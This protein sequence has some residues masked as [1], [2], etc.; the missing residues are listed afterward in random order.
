MKSKQSI[1][2]PKFLKIFGI[3][4]LV[5]L[6][7]FS[8]LALISLKLLDSYTQNKRWDILNEQRNHIE[9]TVVKYCAAD[10]GRMEY[11]WYMYAVLL[12]FHAY[13]ACDD[14]YAELC[15]GDM[16]IATDRDTAIVIIPD[17]GTNRSFVLSIEDISYLDPLDEYMDGKISYKK[18]SDRMI[19]N[20]YDPLFAA[21][22]GMAEYVGD[23]YSYEVQTIYI[24]YEENTFIPGIVRVRNDEGESY[25]VDCTPMDTKG[26]EFFELDGIYEDYRTL[27]IFYRADP[28]LTLDNSDLLIFSFPDMTY[29][30][31]TQEEYELMVKPEIADQK[32]PWMITYT[33]PVEKSVFEL[34]PIS[35]ALIIYISLFLALA[36]SLLLAFVKYQR[37]KTI[38]NIFLYRTKTTEAMAHDLKT[39]LAAIRAYAENIE[40]SADDPAKIREYSKNITDK[41]ESMDQMITDILSLS[42]SESR[43]TVVTAEPVSVQALIKESLTAFPDMKTEITGDDVTLKTDRKLFKQAI[44]NLFSNCDRYGDKNVTVIIGIS[45]EALTIT[46]ST[47]MNYA[48][49]ESL[50]QP[51]VKGDNTRGSK[52]TG[53]GLSIADNNLNILGYRL[54]LT[55]EKRTFT[56]T[57][58]FKA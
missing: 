54:G 4:L 5:C 45:P 39:P 24:N 47:N 18:L 22:P 53:L 36:I 19:K 28:D 23:E 21:T 35:S 51:F 1:T 48:D 52:G 16:K 26:Y 12:N 2:K 10:P 6:G 49:V 17:E 7:A 38:W 44:D 11:D 27:Q 8:I 25:K 56:A 20:N 57:V 42:K 3:R 33:Y 32:F 13:A 34:A 15:I 41:V 43:K 55:S 46:N 37:E 31:F 58:K 14:N 9:E 50:K 29:T 30:C 40:A